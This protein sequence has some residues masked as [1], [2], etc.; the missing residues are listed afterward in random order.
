MYSKEK[1]GFHVDYHDPYENDPDLQR[2]L[3]FNS[4]IPSKRKFQ[5]NSDYE[6]DC[7]QEF[8]DNNMK[9]QTRNMPYF[10]KY[11]NIPQEIYGH[12]GLDPN[13]FRCDLPVNSRVTGITRIRRLL[14]VLH[15][16]VVYYSTPQPVMV[17][18]ISNLSYQSDYDLNCSKNPAR[19]PL[20]VSNSGNRAK[21][22]SSDSAEFSSQGEFSP[23]EKYKH[24]KDY[25]PSPLGIR[26]KNIRKDTLSYSDPIAPNFVEYESEDELLKSEISAGPY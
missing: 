10:C 2:K 25:C 6:S 23:A 8:V 14:P 16:P 4:M 19:I 22:I 12:F 17:R 13:A 21:Y 9:K 11:F 7:F 20:K 26:L 5:P 18:R 3:K 24:K 15:S 1:D